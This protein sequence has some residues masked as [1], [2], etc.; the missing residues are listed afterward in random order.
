MKQG[1]YFNIDHSLPHIQ[2]K[3]FLRIIYLSL[4][5]YTW[6]KIAHCLSHGEADTLYSTQYSERHLELPETYTDI[7]RLKRFGASIDR[8]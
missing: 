6:P 5:P 7:L 2:G 1:V 8:F 3:S 4:Q